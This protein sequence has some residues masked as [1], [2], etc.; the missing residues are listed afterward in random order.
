MSDIDPRPFYFSQIRIDPAND[1]RV[2]V[3][4]MAVLVSD[5]A[6]KNFR[7]DLSGE[8]APGLSC[9]RD[10]TGQRSCA[11]AGQA[12]GQKQAAQ[13]AGLRRLIARD[14]RRCLP[15]LCRGKDLGTSQSYSRGRI[16]PDHVW[17]TRSPIIE[18][19]ADCRITKVS[20]GQARCRARKAFAIAIGCAL[21]GGDGFYVVFDPA[22]RD[23]FYAESQEGFIHRIQ[24]SHRRNTRTAAGGGRRA[25]A[26]SIPLE[27]ASDRKPAQ[28][29]RALSGGQS[30]FSPDRSGPSTSRSSVPD[31]TRND[32]ARIN[33]TGS[34]AEN[35]GVVY[36]LAESPVKS[37]PALGGNG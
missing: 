13:A 10:S 35:F 22:D 31:L 34:G 32:P 17:M 37:R 7:E 14:G 30:R 24:L 8:G 20:P 5:D 25:G 15:E 27:R 36:S 21:S 28:A 26:L 12:G 29:G 19:R 16:L 2:Y 9:A 11:Q 23:I 18:S 33:A 3:L 4:G 6:R 1:Q